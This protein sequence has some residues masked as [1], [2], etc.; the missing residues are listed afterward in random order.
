MTQCLTGR[1]F[2]CA[3]RTSR[4]PWAERRWERLR[5]R[6]TASSRAHLG[7]N[8]AH[9]ASSRVAPPSRLDR[10]KPVQEA[11]SHPIRISSN[12]RAIQKPLLRMS[13]EF[14]TQQETHT[15]EIDRKAAIGINQIA[16]EIA[17]DRKSTRLNS[18]H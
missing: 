5:A 11:R 13:C 6:S 15:L 12:S 3:V 17:I 14:I 7:S 8:R 9:S 18:S 10:D 16:T 4:S 1:M 2:C